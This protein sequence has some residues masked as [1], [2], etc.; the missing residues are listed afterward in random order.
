M[1][2]ERT[3]ASLRP[4]VLHRPYEISQ[5][6]T[7]KTGFG[8][9]PLRTWGTRFVQGREIS[10]HRSYILPTKMENLVGKI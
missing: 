4:K 5:K 2:N 10:G 6:R 1:K 3:L 8:L 9:W 7:T